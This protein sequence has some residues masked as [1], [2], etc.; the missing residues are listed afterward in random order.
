M[1]TQAQRAQRAQRTREVR[2]RRIAE[3]R[4]Y[5]IEKSRR[6]DPAAIDYGRWTIGAI[7]SG[8][9]DPAADERGRVMFAWA[10]KRDYP[11]GL[12]LDDIEAFLMSL[13]QSATE[14]ERS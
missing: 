12:T 10:G 13:E 2:L 14:G 7:R 8:Q 9:N 4:G 11:S 5:R 6:R 1:E 3:R